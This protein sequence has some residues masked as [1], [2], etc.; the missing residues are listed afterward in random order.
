MRRDV[1][2]HLQ[3]LF[4]AALYRLRVPRRFAFPGW[5]WEPSA[6]KTAPCALG[7]KLQIVKEEAQKWIAVRTR[8]DWKHWISQTSVGKDQNYS[9]IHNQSR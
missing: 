1:V 8:Y 4:V 5:G 6:G 3:W 2:V 9:D 7:R